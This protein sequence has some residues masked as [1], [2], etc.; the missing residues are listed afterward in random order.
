MRGCSVSVDGMASKKLATP[1]SESYA[2]YDTQTGRPYV[3]VEFES[4]AAAHAELLSLLRPYPEGHEW[5][6]RLA[7]RKHC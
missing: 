5:W 6:A 3:A 4:Y 1:E 2:I 7:V